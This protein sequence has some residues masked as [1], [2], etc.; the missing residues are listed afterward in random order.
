MARTL[1]PESEKGGTATQAAAVTIMSLLNTVVEEVKWRR[2]QAQSAQPS[3]VSPA[4]STLPV[5][6]DGALMFLF[7]FFLLLFSM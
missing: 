7:S 5:M 1:Q 2:S 3:K 6:C 4:T